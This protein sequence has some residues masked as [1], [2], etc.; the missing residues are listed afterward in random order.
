MSFCLRQIDFKNSVKYQNNSKVQIVCL[1][2][3]P[4]YLSCAPN[5]CLPN[6][7]HTLCN[8]VILQN[9]SVCLPPGLACYKEDVKPSPASCTI[10]CTGIYADVVNEG[11]EDLHS[12][13]NFK[14]VLDK[15]KEY[16]SGFINDEGRQL[17]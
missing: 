3:F 13:M 17:F 5:P 9:D 8:I 7:N 15:Y 1:L 12:M 2:S 6:G 4:I 14:Q 10:P 16:K 11:V